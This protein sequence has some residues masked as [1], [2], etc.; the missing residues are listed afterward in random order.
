M[1]LYGAF[2]NVFSL[3]LAPSSY[4]YGHAFDRDVLYVMRPVISLR[5]NLSRLDDVWRT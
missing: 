3:R 2:R 1:D 5:V 4:F